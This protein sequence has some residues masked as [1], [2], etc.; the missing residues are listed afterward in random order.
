MS[1]G[2]SG[3]RPDGRASARTREGAF[4][5]YPLSGTPPTNLCL[6]VVETF[7]YG[8]DEPLLECTP[9]CGLEI[10]FPGES[11][12]PCCEILLIYDD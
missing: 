3:I 8:P 10:P 9:F 5:P 2:G 4:A 7:D 11:L 6:I 1:G 12:D